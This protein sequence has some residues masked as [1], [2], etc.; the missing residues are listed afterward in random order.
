MNLRQYGGDP[1]CDDEKTRNPLI[2]LGDD[3]LDAFSRAF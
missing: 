3:E 2:G 1:N